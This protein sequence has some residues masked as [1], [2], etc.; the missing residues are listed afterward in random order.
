MIHQIVTR[1]SFKS[2][3]DRSEGKKVV[4]LYPWTN[5]RNLFLS[6]FLENTKDG[7]LYYRIPNDE[8]SLN[9][10]VHGLVSELK[11]VI[12]NFGTSTMSMID[13]ATPN[14]LGEALA[15]DL[16]S[17]AADKGDRCVL[18]IDELDRVPFD[19]QFQRFIHAVV[20]KLSD[21]V[22]LAFSSRLLT[23]QP[24]HDLIAEGKAVVLGTEHRKN[25]VMFTVEEEPKPQLEVYALGRGYALVN[26]QQISNWDGALPRNLFFFFIDRPLVTRDEIFQVFWPSLTVKDAT[27]VFHVTKRKISERITMK[28]DAPGNYELT[29][30]SSGFYMPSDKVVRHYDVADFQE[31][32]EQGLVATDERKEESLFSRA[33]DLYKG[34]FLQTVDMPWVEERRKHLQQY[35]AQS[36][37][38]MGRIFLRRGDSERSLGFF[39]RSLREAPEREDIHREVMRL[40]LKQ[41]MIQDAREQYRRLEEILHETVGIQP[42]R[43]TREVYEMIEAAS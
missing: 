10:W 3:K 16:N 21:N 1:V 22:Q 17:F 38:G 24:W 42:S 28:V 13:D 5:Y 39:S 25:D 19:E 31:A 12:D 37:I 14:E 40:Y 4:L 29:Q 26:G 35:Y 2:F 23:Q 33:I 8:T 20:N 41:G 34:P 9:E 32:V 30:Y 6:H 7:L 11:S 27:N 36:L 18:Y 15:I 43:E